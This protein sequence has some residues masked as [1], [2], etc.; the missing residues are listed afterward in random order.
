MSAK[1]NLDLESIMREA[2]SVEAKVFEKFDLKFEDFRKEIETIKSS[3]HDKEIID[4]SIEEDKI[5]NLEAII[6]LMVQELKQKEEER[7]AKNLRE[8]EA[9]EKLDAEL[10]SMRSSLKNLESDLSAMKIEM[11][12]CCQS[13]EAITATVQQTIRDMLT[14]ENADENTLIALLS[15][16]FATKSELGDINVSIE[17]SKQS[18][19]TEVLEFVNANYEKGNSD[20]LITELMGK[21][22][23]REDEVGGDGGRGE[24]SPRGSPAPSARSAGSHNALRAAPITVRCRS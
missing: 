5:A 9:I 17:A 19:Q 3:V 4:N 11:K 1:N 8:E 12:N 10:T 23:E 21:L 6:E 2:L 13:G 15:K 24:G 18:L 22:K 14:A 7:A 16:Y 20:A